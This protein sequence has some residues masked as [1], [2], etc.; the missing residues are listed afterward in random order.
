MRRMGGG[1]RETTTTCNIQTERDQ[2][3]LRQKQG[4]NEGMKVMS[5]RPRMQTNRGTNRTVRNTACSENGN[6]ELTSTTKG[7]K[8][9]NLF[10]IRDIER[11]T[12]IGLDAFQ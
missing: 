11:Y 6:R 5:Q 4:M 7:R 10:I 2:I 8:E 1:M 12:Y 3:Q 9:G